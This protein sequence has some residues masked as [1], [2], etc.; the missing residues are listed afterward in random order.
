MNEEIALGTAIADPATMEEISRLRTSDFSGVNQDFYNVIVELWREDALS[1]PSVIDKLREESLL[2]V[3][4]DEDDTG[5]EYVYKLTQLADSQG[6][7]HHISRIEQ[8]AVR[9]SMVELAALMAAEAKDRRKSIDEIMDETER[10]IFSLRRRTI[11]EDGVEFNELV[12]SYM[13]YL[14]GMRNGEISPA[15]IPPLAA[16]RDLVEYVSRTEF[17]VLA[18]RPGEGKSSLL[19][20]DA[21]M[22]AMKENPQPVV[23]FNLENDP[24]EYTKFAIAA[25]ANINS[26]KL[27]NP[28]SLTDI[29]LDQVREAAGRIASIPWTIVTLSRP[30]VVQLDRIIRKKVSEGAE[31]IQVDYL[32][33]IS[34]KGKRNR[35]EDVSETTGSLRGTAL[36]TQVPIVA[37]C[38][39]SRAIEYRGETAE[40][41]LSD[42]R[43]SGSIEQDATQI[44]FIRSLWHKDPERDEVTDPNFRFPEN[45][46][47]GIVKEVVQA[48][49]VRVYVKK[50]RNGPIGKTVPI[51]W[52]RSTGRFA[53]IRRE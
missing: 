29:E 53:T 3:I 48:V 32:Q 7:K 9:K 34:N 28:Q 23:T 51:K 22:T 11:E 46:Y 30:T 13:P 37:A 31:L 21:L 12:S 18:G 41:Q 49:P 36:K 24:F 25:M 6:I 27:K 50:N 20:Y 4:G 33:L 1:Y 26:A 17:V 52:T 19:R 42:L 40:P 38:Q 45:F 44:W 43:E 14:E 35:V 47:N 16:V 39:L 15:W 8:K 10:R 2:P 5:E